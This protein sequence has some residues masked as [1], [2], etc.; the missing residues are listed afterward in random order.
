MLEIATTAFYR[1]TYI[2]ITIV[3]TGI[4][5]GFSLAAVKCGLH[6]ER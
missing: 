3:S 1:Y 2:T 5:Y 6:P 4:Y